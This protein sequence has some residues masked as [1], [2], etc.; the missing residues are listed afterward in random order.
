MLTKHAP[1]RLRSRVPATAQAG[2]GASSSSE[3]STI[4]VGVKRKLSAQK[5]FESPSTA[6]KARRKTTSEQS[7]ASSPSHRR[8]KPSPSLFVAPGQQQRT[9][10]SSR[11]TV[12]R[13][14]P[15]PSSFSSPPCQPIQPGEGPSGTGT[16]T[17]KEIV[18]AYSALRRAV[19]DSRDY[20]PW[21]EGQEIGRAMR[22]LESALDIGLLE[23]PADI[24]A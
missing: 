7:Q 2:H 5:E 9:E 10:K 15:S 8:S 14:P 13:P 12:L 20:I 11:P 24:Q 1:K 17:R 23:L 21:D 16:S 6:S 22:R 19:Y 4:T 3:A 18:G